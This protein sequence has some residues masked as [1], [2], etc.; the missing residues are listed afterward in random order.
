[1]KGCTGSRGI[2]KSTVCQTEAL[3]RREGSGRVVRVGTP[4]NSVVPAVPPLLPMAPVLLVSRRPRPIRMGWAVQMSKRRPF[5]KS[6]T[7]LPR[8]GALEVLKRSQ[9]L[10]A[11]ALKVHSARMARVLGLPSGRMLVTVVVSVWVVSRKP[12]V[13]PARAG[14]R[15][16][17]R[18]DEPGVKVSKS[19][20]VCEASRGSKLVTAA[21]N[22]AVPPSAI[23]TSSG[24]PSTGG[25]RWSWLAGMISFNWL[26]EDQLSSATASPA[27]S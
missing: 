7:G 9:G 6:I 19:A 20:R 11:S 26:T 24:P 12:S 21:E 10:T 4:M 3:R 8:L 13:P 2:S 15:N 22:T 17:T 18:S 1:M 5:R 14:R 16:M 23:L 27:P 25:G